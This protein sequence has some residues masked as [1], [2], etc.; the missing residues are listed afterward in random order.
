MA[1]NLSNIKSLGTILGVWAHPDDETFCA[2]GI[3]AAAAKN[4]QRVVIVT[5]T[6]GEKG[7]QD[8]SRWPAD[9]LGQIRSDELEQAL[10]ILG[11]NKHEQ[12]DFPDGACNEQDERLA[13]NRLVALIKA[14]QPDTV[15]TFGPDGLTGHPDH[16]TVSAWATTAV[17]ES[18]SQARLLYAVQTEQQYA[19]SQAVDAKLNLFFNTPKPSTVDEADADLCCKLDDELFDVKMRALLAMPSQYQ[20]MYDSFDGATLKGCFDTEAFVESAIK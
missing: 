7:V 13:V 15:L 2:G 18:G 16:S 10:Q 9:K 14:H 3:L 1:V 19:K 17:K 5:A 20:K 11:V 8:E 4:G 12:L 6:R